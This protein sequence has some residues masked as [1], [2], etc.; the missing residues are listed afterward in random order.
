MITLGGTD[1]RVLIPRVLRQLNSLWPHLEKYVLIGRAFT[2]EQIGLINRAKDKSTRLI[3]FP[4]LHRLREAMIDSDIAISSASQ[5]I[6]ELARVGTPAVAIAAAINQL[7]ILRGSQ[8][9]GF[10]ISAGRWDDARLMENL[11]SGLRRAMSYNCRLAMRRNGL[12]AIDGNGPA[13]VVRAI[14]KVFRGKKVK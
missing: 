4:S 13:R 12:K 2:R 7:H 5:T 8:K 10:I 11:G 6:H 14:M 3:Y 1:H 9:A